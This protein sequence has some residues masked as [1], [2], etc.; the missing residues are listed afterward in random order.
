MLCDEIGGATLWFVARRIRS[1]KLNPSLAST[2]QEV[3]SAGI[4]SLIITR[5][6]EGPNAAPKTAL[7]ALGPCCGIRL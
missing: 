3:R 1:S 2:G 4:Y 5:P 7:S 6:G